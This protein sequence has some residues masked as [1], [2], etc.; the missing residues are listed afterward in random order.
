MEAGRSDLLK[1]SVQEEPKAVTIRLEGRIARPSID[2]LRR[3]WF[4][5]T[6]SLFSKDLLVDLCGVT[7]VDAAGMHLLTD[8]R[9]SGASLLTDT[10]MMKR[11]VEQIEREGR[12][13]AM[14]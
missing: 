6:P 8:I 2:E 12:L 9:K 3:A 13:P 10:P 1:I 5:L 11:L 4:S 14:R 7:F